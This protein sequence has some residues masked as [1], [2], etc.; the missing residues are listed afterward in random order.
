[1]KVF[2]GVSL[3]AA[4]AALAVV[5]PAAFAAHGKAGLWDVTV[6]MQM[7]GMPQ[8]SPEDM[9]RMKAMGMQMPDRNTI[10]TQHCMTAA[11]VNSDQLSSG[12][13][14]QQGCAMRNMKTAGH[15]FS[16]DMI[17][18]GARQGEGHMEITYD[19][20]EHYKG[21]MTFSGTAG[22]QPANITYMYEGKWTSP[23]CGSVA[24]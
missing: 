11:E 5:P 24:H 19:S 8:M 4:V 13:A 1:M 12:S 23:D 22:G 3:F 18:T 2:S 14:A 10:T 15:T 21:N 6:S 7:A 9:V 16:G 20:P 17:C